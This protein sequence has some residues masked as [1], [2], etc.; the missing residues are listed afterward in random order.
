MVIITKTKLIRFYDH[1]TN[2]KEA[3]LKWYHMAEVS[4]W[5]DFHNIKEAFNSV[6]SV[7]NDRYVFN[8]SGN[9]YRLVA[10]IHFTT[11]TVYIRFVGTHKQYDQINCKT[12]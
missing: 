2:A 8:I 3:L 1:E 5:Q 7:G 9:K 10:M 4:D 11:R 6:D 12:I